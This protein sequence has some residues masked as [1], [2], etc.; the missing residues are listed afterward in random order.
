M[1]FTDVIARPGDPAPLVPQPVVAQVLQELPAQSAVLANARRV[2]MS[3]RTNR[4]PA[5]SVL[6]QAYFVSGDVGLK[7]TSKQDWE[8]VILTAE[9]LAVIVPIPQA[10]LDDA[11]IP[12][13][14]EVRLRISE[15]FGSAIDAA[16]LFGVNKPATWSTDLFTAATTAPLAVV[17]PGADL[18]QSIAT[19]G[20]DLAKNG[21]AL[22][23]FAA[24]PGFAWSLAG[25]RNAQGFPIYQ[26]DPQAPVGVGRLYGFPLQEVKSGGWDP[27]K[28][29]VIAGDWTK[30]LVGLRQDMT[31]QVFTEGV[32]SDAA[33]NIVLNL[34]Q[35]DAVALRA[36]MRLAF[37]TAN[38]VTQLTKGK[39]AGSF[40]PFVALGPVTALE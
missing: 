17:A 32:I 37:A 2:P 19:V 29:S 36:V 9:E 24:A 34:M 1:S 21:Y 27:T 25:F 7:Q 38:P 33:G 30:A 6:P 40:Y 35:Q 12:I 14:D 39:A 4:M 8:N 11:D 18:G 5:L 23:G 22:N 3:A 16:A 10:Y 15:A 31:F 28:A 26:P 20:T 13:W